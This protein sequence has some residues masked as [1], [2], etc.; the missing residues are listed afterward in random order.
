MRFLHGASLPAAA[1]CLTFGCGESHP[2]SCDD[3]LAELTDLYDSARGGSCVADDDCVGVG[4]FQHPECLLSVGANDP[5]LA[6][7]QALADRLESGCSDEL[8]HWD[9][10]CAVARCVDGACAVADEPDCL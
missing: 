9:C 2:Q 5:S 1:L 7:I 8:P 3:S 4:S 6:Q 10:R